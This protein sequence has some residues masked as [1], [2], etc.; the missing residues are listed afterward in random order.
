MGGVWCWR[1]FHRAEGHGVG[2]WGG[3]A[4]N[5]GDMLLERGPVGVPRGAP[6]ER[7]G[8]ET[9]RIYRLPHRVICREVKRE[10]SYRLGRGGGREEG[11]GQGRR[12]AEDRG[13]GRGEREGG[14]E[15][16]DQ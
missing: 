14:E 1:F 11:G 4:G 3:K 2:A 10:G 15:E 8:Q 13:G 12:R 5:E 9:L 6:P 7:L 16:K